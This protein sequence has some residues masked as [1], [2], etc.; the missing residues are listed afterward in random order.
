MAP[1]R[2]GR[3]IVARGTERVRFVR[4]RPIRKAGEAAQVPPNERLRVGTVSET[5]NV[6][7]FSSRG[8]VGSAEAAGGQAATGQVPDDKLE[9]GDGEER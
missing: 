4:G 6:A 9:S 8:A 2:S 1:K 7:I 3:G 5:C